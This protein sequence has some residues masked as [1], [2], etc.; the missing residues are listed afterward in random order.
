MPLLYKFDII[1]KLKDKGITTYTILKNKYFSQSTVTKF[2]QKDTNINLKNIE[3][4]C[5]LLDCQPGDILEYKPDNYEII[6]Q[7]DLEEIHTIAAFEGDTI[8]TKTKKG[9]VDEAIRKIKEK[10][11]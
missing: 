4:I 8:I 9:D 11:E 2:N 6:Q 1:P 7:P 3:T 5:K 10:Q